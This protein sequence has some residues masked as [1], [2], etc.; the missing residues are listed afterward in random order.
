MRKSLKIALGVGSVVLI[1]LATFVG[2]I[3]ARI[4]SP[5]ADKIV[6]NGVVGIVDGGSI[7]WV[8]PTATG[9]I[10][11]DAGGSA[12]SDKLRAEVNGRQVHAILLTHGHFDHT[13]GIRDYPDTQILAGPGESALV[14]GEEVAGGW[15][16]RM[17]KPMMGEPDYKP[18]LLREFTDGE[19]IEIDGASITAIH[20]PGH[21][22]GSA[23]YLWQDVLFVGDT[24]VGRG[25]HVSE[26]PKPLYDNYERVPD[27]VAKMDSL[28]FA[29][30]AD[31]HVGLHSNGKKLL[32][33]FVSK[34]K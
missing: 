5:Q 31:G 2:P 12:G 19:A 3:A 1:G 33:A 6:G 15:M 28:D 27:S 26:L 24:V 29:V 8:I 16:A 23:A 34:S 30:I 10:L 25:D 22:K 14:A 17:S 13:A 4:P 21:T 11:I 9:V 18:P 7:T 20:V 32:A